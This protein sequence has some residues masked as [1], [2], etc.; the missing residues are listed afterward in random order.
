MIV[1]YQ[2]VHPH[3]KVPTQATEGSAGWDL[4]LPELITITPKIQ[5]VSLGFIMEMPKGWEASIRP[6]SS[7]ARRRIILVNSPATID[8]DYRG[9]VCVLLKGLLPYLDIVAGERVA[10]MLFSEVPD[11]RWRE[12]GYG[13]SLSSTVR[14]RGGFGSTGK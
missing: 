13:E 7:L 6:R 2:L 1:R 9:E 8:C 10:Q 14:G 12:V 3:A 11:V 4:Y 5:Q